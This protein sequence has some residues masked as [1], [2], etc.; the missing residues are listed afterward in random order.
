LI[1]RHSTLAP[2]LATM[3][4]MESSLVKSVGFVHLRP[5]HVQTKR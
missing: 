5:E 3:A 4:A 1:R 2:A